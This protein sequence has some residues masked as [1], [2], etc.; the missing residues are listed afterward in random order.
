MI[1][2]GFNVSASRSLFDGGAFGGGK[3][4]PWSLPKKVPPPINRYQI[5]RPWISRAG[6]FLPFPF[7]PSFWHFHFAPFFF[8]GRVKK[9][10]NWNQLYTEKSGRPAEAQHLVTLRWASRSSWDTYPE[11]VRLRRWPAVD[12]TTKS[13]AARS[14]LWAVFGGVLVENFNK[15]QEH[16]PHIPKSKYVQGFPS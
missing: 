11:D 6:G 10:G 16:T 4:I 3:Q 15:P 8:S 13:F 14:K 7:C 2:E 12:G 5:D 9:I 1:A